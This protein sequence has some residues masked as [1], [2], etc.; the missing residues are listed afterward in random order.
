METSFTKRYTF[1][2]LVIVALILGITF[3]Y[4]NH[5]DF[6]S[7]AITEGK[8]SPS[9]I[10][11]AILQLIGG[12]IIPILFVMPSMFAFGRIRLT[13]VFLIVYGI[14]HILTSV[15]L[16]NFFMDNPASAIWSTDALEN[17]FIDGGYV[18]QL[19][20][21]DTYGLA[22]IIFSIIYGAAVIYTGFSF[23]KNK[24]LVKWLMILL[25]V[26]RLLLPFLN[27]IIFQGRIYSLFWISNN[28][29]RLAEQLCLTVA[30][31]I[32]GSE[33]NTWIELVWDQ[34]VFTETDAE[35]EDD[36]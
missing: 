33:D 11:Y 20:F 30:I 34:I 13:R 31:F 23:D 17:F 28:Y 25:L 9:N 6:I 26:L 18:Y 7:N 12:I 16:I 15:W 36:E 22:S 1:K 21:W 32:A 35:D 27:N 19:T 3:F 5:I 4:L 24:D 8:M 29:L 10:A 2:A 14:F